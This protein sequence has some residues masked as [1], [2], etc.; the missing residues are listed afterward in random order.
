MI[1]LTGGQHLQQTISRLQKQLEKMDDNLFAIATEIKSGIDKRTQSGVDVNLKPFKKYSKKYKEFKAKYRDVS[2]V[3]LTYKHHMLGAMHVKKIKNGAEI[4]FNDT[5]EEK[6]AKKNQKTRKFFG[7][8]PR[9]RRKFKVG[10]TKG[11]I[12]VLK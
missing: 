12:K 9:Q 3:T 7:T 1:K 6:I 10:V 4:Y 5:A 8:D 2:K 11:V